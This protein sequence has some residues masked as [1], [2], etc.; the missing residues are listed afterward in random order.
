MTGKVKCK[1]MVWSN[2]RWPRRHQCNFNAKKDG[3]C[4]IHH[5]DYIKA[6]REKQDAKYKMQRENSIYARHQRLQKE[7]KSLQ[8]KIDMLM[9]EYCP[10][11][12]TDEQRDRWAKSQEQQS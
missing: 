8:A 4:T 3:F 9:L 11:E 6:K 5:P 7:N 12:M 2:E 1:E 10:E